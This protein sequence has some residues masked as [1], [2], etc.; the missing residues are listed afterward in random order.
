MT[1]LAKL[2]IFRKII[3]AFVISLVICFVE[4]CSLYLSL[5]YKFWIFQVLV[6][7]KSWFF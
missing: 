6:R 2:M 3:V 1:S 5:R 4:M 7:P